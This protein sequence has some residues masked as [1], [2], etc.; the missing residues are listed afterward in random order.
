MAADAGT[1]N[2]FN[3]WDPLEEIIVGT[4]DGARI[5]RADPGLYALEF[6]ALAHMSQ[7][8]SGPF[9]AR[10]LEES[11][12]DLDL[13]ASVLRGLGVVVRRP[14]PVDH[15]RVYRS[16]DW[17]SDGFFNYCPR[18]SLLVLGDTIIETP[19]VLRSRQYE[20]FAYRT[21]LR[22]YF[23]RGARWLSAPRPRLKDSIYR[24]SHGFQIAIDESEPLFDAANIA[25]CGRDL[26][27]LVS[28]SAN[29]LGAR[30]LARTMGPEYR[31]HVCD[32]LR[33]T[34]H[35]DTT[36]V[37]VRPG[38]VLVPAPYVSP[39]NLPPALRSWDVVYVEDVVDDGAGATLLSS[40]WVGLN[41]LMLS[42][43]LAV[44]DRRQHA[45]MRELER[46]GIDLVPLELRHARALG[47]GFHCV[48]LDVRRRGTLES[49]CGDSR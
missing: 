29:Q 25:R 27:Y 16:P 19:M 14:E 12:E 10:V 20:N 3:E 17:E 8:P 6:S 34:V 1:V 42:P 13:L 5:P 7:I 45:L 46:R 40:K 48:T 33:N 18:D 35:I 28:D 38:L 49:Y 2:S 43:S 31:I 21:L 26:F 15:A 41:V 24:K 39:D 37:L 32:R 47:G 11:A 36:L 22:E 30:W 44:V 9:S 4:V 23:E